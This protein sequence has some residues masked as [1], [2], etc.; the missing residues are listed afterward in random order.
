MPAG[1]ASPL[2]A[3][4]EDHALA[5]HPAG[6]GRVTIARRQ[7]GDGAWRETSLPVADLAYAV[8]QLAGMPDV[9]LTQNR[10]F[11]FRRLVSRLAELDALFVDL[12]YHKT[13]HAGSHPRH[14]LDLALE[15]LQ[16][17][18]LPTPSFAIA[19]GRG[20]ALVWLHRPV[21]RAALP[22]WRACQQV[23]GRALRGFGADRLASDATRVLRLVGTCNS[24]SGTLVEA[25]TAT[26]GEPWDFDLLADEILPLPRT[27]LV[28]LR[29]ERIRR[30]GDAAGQG[31]PKP[32]GWFGAAGLWE[33]RLAE[34]QRLR[35]H[36]WLGPLPEGHRD[37]WMLLAGVAV[38]YLVPTA[39]VDREIVALAN[40]VT[41]SR[42]HERETA[43]RMSTVIARAE[44]AARGERVT[45]QGR[46]VDPRY[47][48]R[49]ST[50]IDLLDITESE[51]RTC[52]FRH[53]VSPDIRREHE[54]QRWHIRRA[55]AG[56][57]SRAEYLKHSLTQQ[58]PWE[59][60]GISRR[61][62][63]RR[64]A[65]NQAVAS[66]SGCMVAKP[67]P[68]GSQA[69]PAVAGLLMAVGGS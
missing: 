44:Q 30:R 8:R 49:T 48:F 10:F 28:A 17:E 40:E 20:L 25:L 23:L 29:L 6:L 16:V 64:R 31:T 63:E 5:L 32:F 9:Y 47:R 19:T 59:Q 38:S 43:S 61:T 12:D 69:H 26:A 36:R 22:R 67:L 34:L 52:G 14:V 54:R 65:I 18:R 45:Y 56:G 24:R 11:G 50:I 1:Q 62:W 3:T 35:Q 33:L 57:V 42:W 68:S 46:L 21:P 7:L 58:R 15:N 2:L 51:M 60:E 41:G 13:R 37:V 39:M 53:L 27:E 55:T 4:P 66:P